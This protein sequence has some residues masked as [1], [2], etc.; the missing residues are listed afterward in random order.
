MHQPLWRAG[1]LRRVLPS[2]MVVAVPTL[3]A[4]IGFVLLVE[5][6]SF[7]T[8]GT[9]QG[10]TF[11]IR[12]LTI[13]PRTAAPWLIGGGLLVGGG[14]WLWREAIRFRGVWERLMDGIGLPGTA[15]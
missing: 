1:R 15:R 12:G 13:D 5:L 7:L 3:L 6:C 14:L 11:T 4:V 8:I 2:Y 10:K 9:A